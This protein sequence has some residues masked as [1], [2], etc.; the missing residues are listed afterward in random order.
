MKKIHINASKPYDV[1]LGQGL[2]QEAERPLKSVCNSNRV[3]I[4]TDDIV[5]GFYGTSLK[6]S[7][8]KE[9]FSVL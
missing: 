8:E 4:V 3:V 6:N 7:L 1:L 9:K 2:L 5:D